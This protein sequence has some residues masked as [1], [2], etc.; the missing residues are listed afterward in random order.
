LSPEEEPNLGRLR[1]FEFLRPEHEQFVEMGPAA[2]VRA[3]VADGR[4][5]SCTV[6]RTAERLLGRELHDEE[7][8]WVRELT[9][10]FLESDFRY[11]ELVR[12]IVT[13]DT[14]RRAL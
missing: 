7:E 13:S 10:R 12:A 3:G 11:R 1:A 8:P 14:Y 5:T 4:I 6:R 2:L 9:G